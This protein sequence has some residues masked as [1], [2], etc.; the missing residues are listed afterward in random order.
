MCGYNPQTSTDSPDRMDALVW[1]ITD[2]SAGEAEI[3]E[4]V[5][6]GEEIS[7]SSDLDELDQRLNW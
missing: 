1:A 7:I 3:E 2:L 4:T 5:V 6:T